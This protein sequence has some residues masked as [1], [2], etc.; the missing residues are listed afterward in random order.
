MPL[1]LTKL[2][3]KLY[4]INGSWDVLFLITICLTWIETKG[5]TLEEIEEVISGKP[6]SM[7]DVTDVSVDIKGTEEYTTGRQL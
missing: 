3:W 7:E 5:R 1:A 2:G 4:I 6:S